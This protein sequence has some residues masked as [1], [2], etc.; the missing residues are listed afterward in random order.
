MQSLSKNVL[1]LKESMNKSFRDLR[2]EV[3][4]VVK[5]QP[6]QIKSLLL[7]NFQI[8]GAVPL[9]ESSLKSL[10][11]IFLAERDNRLLA[12]MSSIVNRASS[13][14]ETVGQ[15][16]HETAQAITTSFL[17][18]EWGGRSR[19]V[20]ESF[21]FPVGTV[22]TTFELWYFGSKHLRIRPYNN[23]AKCLDDLKTRQN[24]ARFY[25]ARMVISALEQFIQ[26]NH[27]V[28]DITK[29]DSKVLTEAFDQAYLQLL[30]HCHNDQST[31]HKRPND[32]AVGIFYDRMIKVRKQSQVEPLNQD[33]PELEE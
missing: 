5:E 29:L 21:Q 11:D 9:T 13:S 10:L 4:T 28:D 15:Y 8:N 32:V 12:S 14:L 1:S 18:Y 24:K 3:I 23:F 31:P 25:K 7:N 33:E 2:N 6:E 17:T 30:Q 20:P 22:K 27:P 26:Q 19:M 16:G